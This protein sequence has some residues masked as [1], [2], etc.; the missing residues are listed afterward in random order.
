[1]LQVGGPI[2]ISQS[3]LGVHTLTSMWLLALCSEGGASRNEA[4]RPKLSSAIHVRPHAHQN[5]FIQIFLTC[6][7][8]LIIFHKVKSQT[9]KKNQP[10]K[11][12]SSLH[13]PEYS[14]KRTFTRLAC[15]SDTSTGAALLCP[16]LPPPPGVAFE[17]DARQLPLL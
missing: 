12:A 13:R 10:Q 2:P 9:Q 11:R 4:L 6:V 16:A 7:F 1:V 14:P 15:T 5:E 8:I 3:T 17:K